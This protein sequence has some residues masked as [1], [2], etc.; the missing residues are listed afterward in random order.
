MRLL[1]SLVESVQEYAVVLVAIWLGLILLSAAQPVLA[2]GGGVPQLTNAEAGPYRV[3]AWTQP[4]PIR[5]GDFHISVAVMYPPQSSG[6]ARESGD[7]VLDAT[8]AVQLE[9]LNR[10]GETLLV[11]AS[12]DNAVNKLYYETD[13]VLPDAGWWRVVVGVDGPL[14]AGQASFEIEALPPNPLNSLQSLPGVAWG[15]LV[16]VLLAAGWLAQAFRTRSTE[17]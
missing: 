2:H 6:K 8:V 4:D 12:R 1:R 9:P 7:L 14:G 15:G 3:S 11:S 10:E 16:L 17:A 5:V 13:P